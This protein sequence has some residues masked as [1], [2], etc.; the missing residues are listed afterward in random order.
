M[1]LIIVSNRL[2]VRI[3]KRKGKIHIRQSIGGLV[4]GLNSACDKYKSLW[5]GWPGTV[6]DREEESLVKE[7]LSEFNCSPIFLSKSDVEGYYHGFSNKAIWPLF[8][9][10]PQYSV[11][12][13][14]DWKAYKNVNNIFCEKIM[15]ST[16][17]VRDDII[18]IHDYHLMLLPQLIREKLPD[19]KIGFFLHIPFPSFEI[20]RL[21]PCRMEILEG[22]LGAD[23][24]GFHT[25]DYMRHFLSSVLRLLGLNHSL[26]QIMVENRQIKIDAFP[27]GIDYN[28]FSKS[29]EDKKVQE[30]IAKFRKK[31]QGLKIIISVD[32]LDYTKGII[33]RLEGFDLFLEKYPEWREKLILILVAT[34]SRIKVGQYQLLK[35]EIDEIIGRING[36][37]GKLGWTPIWYL[38]RTLPFSEL[39][40]LYNIADV[41]LITPLRDGMN[42]IAK[43]YIATRENNYGVLILSETTGASRELG[44]AIVINSVSKE[45]IADALKEALTIRED[46]QISL[47]K[48]MQSRLKRYDIKRWH[49]DFINILQDV[50][51]SQKEVCA[52]E[53]N[54][55]EQRKLLT[56]Y[57]K[58]K[59]RLIILDYDGTLIPF[60][61][62]PEDAIP[63]AE[64][65]NLLKKLSALNK[66][67]TILVSGRNK[68]SLEQWFGNL[69]ISLIA[70]HGALV[71]TRDTDSW[72]TVTSFS[73]K[74]EQPMDEIEE[75]KDTI[76][77]ILELTADRV[78]GSFVEEKDFS[79]V[80]HYRKA[81]PELASLKAKQLTDELINLTANIN[82]EV[83]QGNKVVE[84][85]SALIDKGKAL[86]PWISKEDYDFI[87]A[88]GDDLTDEDIF[89]T[90][91]DKAY[92]IKVGVSPTVA[93]FRLLSVRSVRTLLEKMGDIQ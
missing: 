23:L 26:G 48:I 14:S 42:L 60:A 7:K 15:S 44:E 12:D 67:E 53:L 70:E 32:R 76:M 79:L 8:H 52:E 35:K 28:K 85:K 41:A 66:N 5:F 34:P 57:Q 65:L 17:S 46:R 63:D 56:D 59:N 90:L 82:I 73:A 55:R 72:K 64:L 51:K 81:D 84:V 4:S 45:E 78:P 43:E 69:N 58:S 61:E 6:F 27:M 36:K 22:I 80:W 54:L 50:K 68:D 62:K 88:I 37:Y 87:L 20:F 47:N 11:F 16:I 1:K 9:Y 19:A 89:K 49:E 31:T 92:P 86:L 2:P 24:I 75:W 83:L 33:Q 29:M 13:K 71:K 3:E 40:A 91:P 30:N 18:W 21:L 77:P 10:F 39:T 25:Y 74:I 93:K 38:Y